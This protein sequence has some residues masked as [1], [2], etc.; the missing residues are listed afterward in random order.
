M[1]NRLLSEDLGRAVSEFPV[2]AIIGPRQVGKTTL[3][4]EF[5][6]SRKDGSRKY[7]YLDLEL[8]SDMARLT[9]AEMYLESQAD[10]LVIID[11]IQRRPDLFPLLRALVD[12]KRRAGRFLIL[13]SAN[14]LALR[15]ISESL[16]GRIQFLELGP[17]SRA[18]A[19][20]KVPLKRHWLRGGYPEAVLPRS[21]ESAGRWLEALIRSYLERDLN[22]LGFRVAAPE[23]RR[24][25][26]MLA[27][28]HGQP[29]NAQELASSFG[30][31]PP[32]AT[33]YRSILEQMFLVRTLP[34][35]HANLKKRLVKTPRVYIRDSGILHSL[36][37]IGSIDDLLAHPVAGK[38]WEG[39]VLEQIL[40]TGR[41]RL[42]ASF[43][44]T[45]AGAEID[46]VIHQGQKIL[47]LVEMKLGLKPALTRG[48]HEARKDLG[49]PK[50]WAVYS[51]TERYPLCP[52]VDAI[53][54][55]QFLCDV[56]P[57]LLA[58]K[59]AR[60]RR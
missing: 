58:R 22:Q 20:K 39:F 47:A 36:L 28:N 12:K 13:G 14:L 60:P 52:G 24:F 51:G 27:H 18:E 53:G 44:R 29:W 33:H 23:L 4:K 54:V 48:F 7:L 34:A 30:V 1:I 41:G 2:V 57:G 55:D 32:T 8:G 21:D 26:T 49:Q 6:K 45:H 43:F 40:E 25:W 31:T 37:G 46:L 11:E 3:A 56:V 38:S 9:D 42:E 19:G 17:F 59:N 35:W 10:R 50:G 5:A 15:Q 16:A